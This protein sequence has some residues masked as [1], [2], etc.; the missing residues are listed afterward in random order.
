MKKINKLGLVIF[1]GVLCVTFTLSAF[2]LIIG[3]F[4]FKI[5][6]Q[7]LKFQK[8]GIINVETQP[9]DAIFFLDGKE[10]K[11]GSPLTISNLLPGNY[12]VKITKAGYL[13]WNATINVKPGFVSNFD[14]LILNKNENNISA[15]SDKEIE[16][17]KSYEGDKNI[18]I[19]NDEIY[20]IKDKI[21]RLVTRLSQNIK[22]GVIMPGEKYVIYQVGDQIKMSEIDGSRV[23]NIA[24]LD[25]DETAKLMLIS[26]GKYLIIAQGE[27]YLKIELY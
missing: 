11:V 23:V 26:Q 24:S 12:D 2:F 3:T 9:K 1:W 21:P 17:I 19:Q 8:T 14:Y 5:N 18:L 22:A 4:G 10:I 13:D 16:D 25:I 15:P 7:E 20:L 6:W 27:K